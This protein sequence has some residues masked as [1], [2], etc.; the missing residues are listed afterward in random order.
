MEERRDAVRRLRGAVSGA[1]AGG[2]LLA[3]GALACELPPGVRVESQRLA[4]SFRTTPAK[5]AVGVPFTLELAACPKNGA[6][7][8]DRV[9]FDAHMPEHRHGMNYRTKVVPLGAGRFESEGWLFHMPGRW[10]FV[11]DL[12]PERLTH[13]VRVE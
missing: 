10:E 12:G 7:K 8:L 4:V 11:F 2:F 3:G 13:S 1:I 5:I 6:L 9:R